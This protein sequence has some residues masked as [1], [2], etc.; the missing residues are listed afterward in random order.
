[1]RNGGSVTE[2]RTRYIELLKA[3]LC[4]SLYDESA[5]RVVEGPLRQFS[6]DNLLGHFKRRFLRAIVRAAKKRGLLLVRPFAFRL[7]DR[8]NG[9]DWPMFGYTMTGHKRL[10]CLQALLENIV[11]D[12]IPGDVVETGVWRGGSMILA[13]A[14]LD[15]LGDRERRIWC[16]DS[17]EGMPKPTTGAFIG[18][19]DL[20]DFDYLAASVEDVKANFERFG[21]LTERVR[22]LKG[23]FKDT[24][25][26]ADI[27]Q[28][29][30]LRL[31]G[32]LYGSTRDALAVLG[33]KVS[34]GGYVIVDDYGG[35]PG[36][37]Q[38]VTEYR[39]QHGITSPMTPIDDDAVYWQV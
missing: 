30:L 10:D 17:F 33:H 20:S 32:D 27:G 4:A 22:F 8:Q 38:A 19:E 23:W 12:N 24:L 34:R 5:W 31:D 14:L 3:A 29:S 15:Q 13:S 21:V 39:D 6:A 26:N 16:C 36:C 11:A 18:S 35:W 9:K 7:S 1:M 28:I 37:R 25:P 2:Y